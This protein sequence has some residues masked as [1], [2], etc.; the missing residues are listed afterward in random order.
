[1]RLADATL[2]TLEV[3]PGWR[4]MREDVPL[5]K[6]YVVD[7]DRIKMATMVNDELGKSMRLSCIWVV[8][9]PPAGWLPCLAFASGAMNAN[10]CVDL[11]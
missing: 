1:M 4:L 9:P 7:L 5:G 3:E 10:D 11:F 2:V 8:S 6:R